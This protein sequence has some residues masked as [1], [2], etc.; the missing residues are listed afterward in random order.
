MLNARAPVVLG[1][2]LSSLASASLVL[3]YPRPAAA[4][5]LAA[6]AAKPAAK[7][8]PAG[9]T[10][11]AWLRTGEAHQEKGEH[12]QAG[13]AYRK[14]L[15][16][17]SHKMQGADEGARAAGFSADAHWLAFEQD[18]GV[19][20]L[21][22]AL[23]VLSLWL[24]LTGPQSRASM[25]DEVVRKFAQIRA[26]R[27]PL[28]EADAAL[29]AGE[30]TKAAGLYGDVV[31]ALATQ[32]YEWPL[33][34]RIALRGSAGIVSVYEGHVKASEDVAAH[35]PALRAARDLLATQK[36]K[37]PADDA[38]EQGPAV[39]QAL[40]DVEARIAAADKKSDGSW[41]DRRRFPARPRTLWL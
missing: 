29:A 14:A 39:D 16:A 28:G 38:S 23:D 26:V 37:R 5:Q 13:D 41:L 30:A 34:A 21:Q 4:L 25:H 15:E 2:V 24:T 18:L 11:S 9:K 35:L 31:Y 12:A 19:L 10:S 36:A 7:P 40:A 1:L 33:R 8:A 17:L 20:H 22:A 32:G 6:P 3:A 27:D